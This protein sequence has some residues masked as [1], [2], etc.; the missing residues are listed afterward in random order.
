MTWMIV[1]L[2]NPG[3]DYA[4]TRHNVGFMVA[5]ELAARMHG[6][7]SRHKRAMAGVLEG[8]IGSPGA[9]A[10]AVLV[11][12]WSFMNASGGPVKALLQFYDITAGRL[13]VIHDELDLP[14]E[15][16]RIKFGGGDNGH[17]G[18]KSLRQSL[19]TGDFTRVRF[20]IGRPPGRQDPAAFVLKPFAG[21]ERDVVAQEVLRSA[22]AVET[23]VLHG[24]ERAQN[25]C[26]GG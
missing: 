10:R 15:T 26:N 7:F 5:D 9:D 19:G 24:L 23:L 1:G 18:L 6:T 4:T 3:P 11:E 8:R 25:D 2:G 21:S 20:G 17:N 14:L 13:V 22:D 16:V 12:P